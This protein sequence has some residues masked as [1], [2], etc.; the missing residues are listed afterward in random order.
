ME[1]S[2]PIVRIS[3]FEE[4]SRM[5]KKFTEITDKLEIVWR[6]IKSNPATK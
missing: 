3:N 1:Q 4:H 2:Q 6:K 5:E